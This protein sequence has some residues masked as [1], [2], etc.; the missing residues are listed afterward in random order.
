VFRT[1]HKDVAIARLA[2]ERAQAAAERS[3]II[4]AVGKDHVFKSVHEAVTALG[5]SANAAR[6]RAE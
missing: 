4:A 3:G 1:R 5:P 6:E 2:N